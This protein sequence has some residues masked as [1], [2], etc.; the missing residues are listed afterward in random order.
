VFACV[1]VHVCVRLRFHL[2]AFVCVETGM[3]KR[4]TQTPERKQM[5]NYIKYLCGEAGYSFSFGV[6]SLMHK[7]MQRLTRVS[8]FLCVCVRVVGVVCLVLCLY[9]NNVYVFL[10]VEICFCMCV[11]GCLCSVA[12]RDGRGEHVPMTDQMKR[13]ILDEVQSRYYFPNDFFFQAKEGTK[14]GHKHKKRCE[15]ALLEGKDTNITY[16]YINQSSMHYNCISFRFEAHPHT[17]THTHTSTHT[18]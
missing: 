11:C 10:Y 18:Q 3:G 13:P 9:K 15:A 7:S 14:V 4:A 5:V 2:R 6:Q 16:I 8:C 12:V 17:H 1:H